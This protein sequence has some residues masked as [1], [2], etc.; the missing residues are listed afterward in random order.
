[1][2]ETGNVLKKRSGWQVNTPLEL[3]RDER[4]SV[5]T[6]GLYAMLKSYDE[7]WQFYVSQLAKACHLSKD[8]LQKEL[9]T[10]ETY[11]YLE[12]TRR[13]NEKGQWCG[14]TWELIDYPSQPK[15][16]ELATEQPTQIEQPK[17]ES[18]QNAKEKQLEEDFEKLWE[19]Y[20]N[21]KGKTAA[22][23]AYKRAI[24][25]GTT[26]KE[27]QTG[28]VAYKKQIAINHTEKQYIKHGGTFFNQRCWEDE[29]LKEIVAT[30]KQQETNNNF[31]DIDPM[32]MQDMFKNRF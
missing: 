21:K 23:K 17:K 1:M 15:Q 13:K 22:F 27:I 16:Q 8:T 2:K 32:N 4:M 30:P 7:G 5:R 19:L 24:K 10:L 20:P 14:Y 25:D 6:K 26:N 9:K 11:G 12:R 28:I 31:S 29:D 3:W 18:V